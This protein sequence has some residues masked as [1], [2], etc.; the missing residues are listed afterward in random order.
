[1]EKFEE[2][3]KEIEEIIKQSP[4][5]T[6]MLHSESTLKWLLVLK[7]DADQALQIAALGHDIE[8]SVFRITDANLEDMKNYEQARKEHSMR[9]VKV[10]SELLEKHNFEKEF[11]DKIQLLVERHE[12][13]GDE[14]S[15]ILRDADSI[16]FFE[17][18]VPVYLKRN[19]KEKALFKIKYMFK[20]VSDKA[21]N[22]IGNVNYQDKEISDLIKEVLN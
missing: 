10:I 6:D 16:A 4:V 20:R 14:E 18:N 2:I 11:I 12:T 17:H 15:D 9:S 22:I 21:K 8:R 5:P 19:G 1:M 7:P 13:G 3:K